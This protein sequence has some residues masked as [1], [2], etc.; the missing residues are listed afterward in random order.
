MSVATSLMPMPA[1]LPLTRTQSRTA[2]YVQL[3][4][5]RIALM[6]LVTVLLGGWLAAVGTA[7]TERLLHAVISTALVTASASALNQYLER[8]SD[9]RMRRTMNR[10][11]PAGRLMPAE[12]LVVGIIL[13]VVGMA[14]QMMVLPPAAVAATAFT[15]ISYVAV[16]TPCKTRTTLNTLIGAVPGAMPPVIGWT[17]VRGQVDAGAVALFLILFFWQVPHFLA[18]AWM[19][20]EE[21]A[22]A[23][24]KMLP[25]TDETGAMTSRQMLVYLAA[26]VPASLFAGQALGAGWPYAVGATLLALYYLKPILVFRRQ[27]AFAPAKSV[28]KASLV[29]LPGLLGLLLAAK[30]LPN[31]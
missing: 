5:P 7:P 1:A 11:L 31:L 17:A 28:L 3:A 12:V 16:Y 19:Y 13:G 26:L 25:V 23:G 2:D 24:H 22:R 10:P 4:R 14:Y 21:Y 9:G 15:L 8:D 20:R 27:P 29:Y 30:Y 6:V 18:I